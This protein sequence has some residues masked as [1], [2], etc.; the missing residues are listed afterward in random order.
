M[1]LCHST[2]N[3]FSFVLIKL[4]QHATCLKMCSLEKSYKKYFAIRTLRTFTL[5]CGTEKVISKSKEPN[6]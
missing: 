6:T 2:C 3:A 4:E 5:A 1:A